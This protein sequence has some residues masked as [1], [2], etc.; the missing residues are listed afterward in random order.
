MAEIILACGRA[1][2]VD[3]KDVAMLSQWTWSLSGRNAGNQYATRTVRVMGTQVSLF[4]HRVLTEAP[5]GIPVDHVNG[6]GL[7]N[8]RANLRLASTSLNNVNRVFRPGPSGY[9]GVARRPK[10]ERYFASAML[11]RERYFFGS[12]RTAEDAAIAYDIGAAR[13]HGEFARLNFPDLIGEHDRL[14]GEIQARSGRLPRGASGYFG[15]SA[16][17]A[18]H[19]HR[20][21]AYICGRDGMI[22]LGTADSAEEAARIYDAAARKRRGASANLNFPDEAA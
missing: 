1:V 9:R 11:N 2:L 7:D 16:P 18:G 6:D 5:K 17:R 21:T 15:V 10:G 3:D 14:W 19:G 12:Y 13:L 20:Y 4:M 8:R 22:H